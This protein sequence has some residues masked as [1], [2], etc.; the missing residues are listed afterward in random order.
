M[1]GLPRSCFQ[2]L[3]SFQAQSLDLVLKYKSGQ[4]EHEFGRPYQLGHHENSSRV[5]DA[6]LMSFYVSPGD[7]IVMGSDG[8]LDNL[9]EEEIRAVLTQ[10]VSKDASPSVMV[11]VLIKMAFE[12]SVDRQRTTPYSQGASDAFDMVY[13][14]GKPDDITILVA[15]CK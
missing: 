2:A 4:L 12:A 10:L 11:Q 13:N 7:I 6:D 3:V 5:D 1:K 15:Q 14:G 9:N 8:L